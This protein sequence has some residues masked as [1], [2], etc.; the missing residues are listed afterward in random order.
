MSSFFVREPSPAALERREVNINACLKGTATL[1]FPCFRA[2]YGAFWLQMPSISPRTG[3][4]RLSIG[5]SQLRSLPWSCSVQWVVALLVALAVAFWTLAL[6]DAVFAGALAALLLWLAKSDLER[7][8]LPDLANI[9]VAA[10]GL[11]WVATL[12][13]PGPGLLEAALR[14]IAAAAC[15]A[16]VNWA[17]ARVR[18]RD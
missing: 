11:A 9:S 16:A 4:A 10:L 13:D 7:F 8:Q 1:P 18:G 15:L 3:R 5:I 14:A 17:Y 2:P 12:N 6:G